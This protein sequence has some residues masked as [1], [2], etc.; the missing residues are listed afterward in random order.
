MLVEDDPIIAEMVMRALQTG[1]FDVTLLHSGTEAWR[2]LDHFSPLPSVLV[3]DINAGEGPDG[4]EIALYARG[5][6]PDIAVVYMTGTAADEWPVHGVS[7]SIL[8]PK[9]FTEIQ[10][11]T[12]VCKLVYG[13]RRHARPPVLHE[14]HRAVR[15][16]RI[17]L[18]E[19]VKEYREAAILAVWTGTLRW[20]KRRRIQQTGH[21][22]K[23][24]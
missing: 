22:L 3:T 5:R 20:Q 14:Q 12:A 7:E 11:V 21:N 4:W 2:L 6:R 10:I 24:E 23:G 17:P 8:V 15:Q 1:G 13:H 9:P 19:W 18:H 16:M